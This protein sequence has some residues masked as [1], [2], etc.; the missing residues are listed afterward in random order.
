MGRGHNRGMASSGVRTLGRRVIRL[1]LQ[2]SRDRTD[3]IL[4]RRTFFG[5]EHSDTLLAHGSLR[6]ATGQDAP[7]DLISDLRR[8]AF[9][10]ERQYRGVVHEVDP[11]APTGGYGG[12]LALGG[13]ETASW[14]RPASGDALDT[15]TTNR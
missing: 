2:P 11:G 4:R 13:M 5:T 10:L 9:D 1:D 14:A 6:Y 3:W 12:Q 7:R 8:I 15:R